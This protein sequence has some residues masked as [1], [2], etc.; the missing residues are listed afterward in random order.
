MDSKNPRPLSC[1]NPGLELINT[2]LN[3][4]DRAV[5]TQAYARGGSIGVDPNITMARVSCL[6]LNPS[7]FHTSFPDN[8]YPF[9][10]ETSLPMR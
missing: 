1:P 3:L 9:F 7:G 8:I 2:Y 10:P 5:S 6:V 4:K